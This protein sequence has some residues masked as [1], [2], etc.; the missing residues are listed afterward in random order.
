MSASLLYAPRDG[1]AAN[2]EGHEDPGELFALV[3]EFRNQS[4]ILMETEG[5]GSSYDAVLKQS[6]RLLERRD[7]LRICF[8]RLVYEAGNS[9]VLHD[10]KRMQK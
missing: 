4:P 2:E 8:V 6:Q 7:V 9:L 3:V 5:H 1:N 10:M